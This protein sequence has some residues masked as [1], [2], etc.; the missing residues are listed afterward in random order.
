MGY[1]ETPTERLTMPKKYK[2]I[3]AAL[4]VER[5]VTYVIVM[6][7]FENLKEAHT[8]HLNSTFKKGWTKGYEVGKVLGHT[9]RATTFFQDRNPENMN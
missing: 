2:I 4:L 9:E 3:V 5:A 1:N 6:K 8:K 7:T